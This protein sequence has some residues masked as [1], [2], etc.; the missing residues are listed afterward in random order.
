[1]ETLLREIEKQKEKEKEMEQQIEKAT[2]YALYL[3]QN[4][5]HQ[6]NISESLLQEKEELEEKYDIERMTVDTMEAYIASLE[7][8]YKKTEVSRQSIQKTQEC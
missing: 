8:D 7:D 1:M 3:E 2:D 6:S 5:N 4:W